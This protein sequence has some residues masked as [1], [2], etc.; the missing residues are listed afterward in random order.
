MFCA[1]I[2]DTIQR[3]SANW[4][5]TGDEFTMTFVS[6]K[7]IAPDPRKMT[8]PSKRLRISPGQ[9]SDNPWDAPYVYGSIEAGDLHDTFHNK[10]WENH[11]P[12]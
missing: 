8:T 9:L 2:M 3:I 4:W 12:F 5:M 1:V 11:L 7:L 6:G 10:T